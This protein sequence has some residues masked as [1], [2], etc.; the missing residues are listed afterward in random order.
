MDRPED[1][2]RPD[3]LYNFKRHDEISINLAVLKATYQSE[4]I[5]RNLALMAGTYAQIQPL[6]RTKMGP[7][8]E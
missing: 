4:L 8:P 2:L 6:R 7:I 5:R 3:F 1:N